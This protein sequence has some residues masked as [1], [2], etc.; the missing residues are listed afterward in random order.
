[1]NVKSEVRKSEVLSLLAMNHTFHRLPPLAGGDSLIGLRN[2]GWRANR[3][4][5]KPS[6]RLPGLPPLRGGT[7]GSHRR[8]ALA[9]LPGRGTAPRVSCALDPGGGRGRAA[10]QLWRN[11]WMRWSPGGAGCCCGTSG[12]RWEW[13]PC[14]F[15]PCFSGSAPRRL[16]PRPRRLRL[17]RQS[18]S[19]RF[20][21]TTSN[22]WRESLGDSSPFRAPRKSLTPLTRGAKGLQPSRQLA[23]SMNQAWTPPFASYPPTPSRTELPRHFLP[24]ERREFHPPVRCALHRQRAG[25]HPAGRNRWLCGGQQRAAIRVHPGRVCHRLAAGAVGRD[26]AA[27]VPLVL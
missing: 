23:G 18:K 27:W 19:T 13:R 22:C 1:M 17:A 14:G 2:C 11:C 5:P 21:L 25:R 24:Y 6:G 20:W 15:W 8:S 12:P 26:V 7:A 10:Q 16:L 4:N 3:P 9:G